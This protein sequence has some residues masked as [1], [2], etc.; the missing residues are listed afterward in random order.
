MAEKTGHSTPCPQCG[1]TWFRED[2]IVQLDASV[3]VARGMKMPAQTRAVGYQYT[4]IGCGRVFDE[5]FAHGHLDV[6]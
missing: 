5:A 1:G 4:C 3:M 6:R 2:R